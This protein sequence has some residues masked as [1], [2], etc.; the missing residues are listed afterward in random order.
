MCGIPDRDNGR[1]G[2]GQGR[3]SQLAYVLSAICAASSIFVWGEEPLHLPE[4]P[5]LPET[6]EIVATVAGSPISAYSLRK[7]L[8]LHGAEINVRFK[9]MEAKEEVLRA[10]IH[11]EV[12]AQAA[13]Y[14]SMTP[15]N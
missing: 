12:L 5:G 11:R 13:G 14:K 1:H 6:R 3:R 2:F 7:A 9:S 8:L 10:L 4:P 15:I